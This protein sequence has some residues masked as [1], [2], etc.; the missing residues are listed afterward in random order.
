MS[1]KTIA[2][3]VDRSADYGGVDIIFTDGTALRIEGEGYETSCVALSLLTPEDRLREAREKQER[4]EQD[5]LAAI[6]SAARKTE[7]DAVKASSTTKQ[8]EAWMDE[9]R[10]GW[11][12][13]LLMQQ[14]FEGMQADQRRAYNRLLY[15]GG[16]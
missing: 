9:H 8:Y 2:E 7:E 12:F 6:R 10:P 3:I 13:A 4:L 15:G 1:G 11:R 14:E 5:R 16:A